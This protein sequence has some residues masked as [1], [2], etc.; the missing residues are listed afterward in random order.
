VE[1]S[2]RAREQSNITNEGGKEGKQRAGPGSLPRQLGIGSPELQILESL[3]DALL[4]GFWLCK[5]LLRNI[6]TTTSTTPV[7]QVQSIILAL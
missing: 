7:V 6:D 5:E 4:F 2:I 1:P 3:T